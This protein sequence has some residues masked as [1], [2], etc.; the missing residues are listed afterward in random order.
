MSTKTQFDGFPELPYTCVPNVF[1]DELRPTGGIG[2]A[3]ARLARVGIL[4]RT[5]RS[6]AESGNMPSS[7]RLVI[8]V[9]I[10]VSGDVKEYTLASN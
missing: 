2:K 1:F 4:T 9:S 8:P 5:H 6:D 10:T 3:L 7:Y